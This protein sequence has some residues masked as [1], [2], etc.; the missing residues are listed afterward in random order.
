MK[1]PLKYMYAPL[2]RVTC[3][4]CGKVTQGEVLWA[5]PGSGFTLLTDAPVLTL[6]KKFP[7]SA[8]AQMFGLCGN[9]IGRAIN[10]HLARRVTA[11]NPFIPSTPT[12][13]LRGIP[14]VRTMAI[15][16]C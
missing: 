11:E 6:A 5:C 4:Q 16:E 7:V 13:T 9:R 14:K 15:F 1:R 10:V 8:I 12:E 3:K 2:P